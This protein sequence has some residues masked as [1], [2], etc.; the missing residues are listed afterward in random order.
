VV[1]VGRAKAGIASQSVTTS[2]ACA[3]E[4]LVTRPQPYAVTQVMERNDK[5]L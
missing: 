2:A 5:T 3:D 4:L 1:V